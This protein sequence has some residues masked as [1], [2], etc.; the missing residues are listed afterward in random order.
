V[1]KRKNVS[2]QSNFPLNA[3]GAY[4]VIGQSTLGR[5]LSKHFLAHTH[6]HVLLLEIH[7]WTTYRFYPQ[8]TWL[9]TEAFE[10]RFI[11]KVHIP[12]F[13]QPRYV[14]FDGDCP[15]VR[16]LQRED[17]GLT[18]EFPVFLEFKALRSNHSTMPEQEITV[19]TRKFIRNP[20][21][22]RKQMVV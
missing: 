6:L 12:F 15:G 11:A 17:F 19:R 3:H 13:P 1:L 18:F 14:N 4:G 5:Y 10:S 22:Q 8:L 2:Q 21:L 9:R 20:L 7:T 16:I